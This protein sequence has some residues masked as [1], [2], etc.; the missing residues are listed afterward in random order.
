MSAHILGRRQIWIWKKEVLTLNPKR[1][2]ERRGGWGGGCRS[3]K[4]VSSVVA[5]AMRSSKAKASNC[6]TLRMFLAFLK[7]SD[8]YYHI[9]Q[10]NKNVIKWIVK[11]CFIW[12]IRAISHMT[13]FYPSICRT[14]NTSASFTQDKGCNCLYM[15]GAGLYPY[16]K[17]AT[18]ET[19]FGENKALNITC[20]L[21]W[22][23][24][25][26]LWFCPAE[27]S[28][29]SLH[30]LLRYSTVSGNWSGL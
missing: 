23:M 18:C 14:I 20:L 12:P 28:N 15:E 1:E 10:T 24:F 2:K 19:A 13:F 11:P 25:R 29:A 27:V 5:A 3:P 8:N 16:S 4:F 26:Y 30:L 17:T 22:H 6:C 21:L 9:E 7:C